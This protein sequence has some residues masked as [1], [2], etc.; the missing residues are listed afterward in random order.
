VAAFLLNVVVGRLMATQRS[1]IATLKAFGYSRAAISWHFL[2]FTTVIVLIGTALGIAGGAW[3]GGGLSRMYMDVYRFPYLDYSIRGGV[4]LVSFA[5]SIAAAGAGTLFAV[6]KAAASHPRWLQPAILDATAGA[7]SRRRLSQPTRMIV[8]NI[9]R[10]PVKSLLSIGGVAM[11]TA[12]LIL[13]VSRRCR[14]TWSSRSCAEL[15]STTS[16]LLFRACS[17]RGRCWLLSL[18]GV[19]Y[20][21]P[22]RSVAARFRFNSGPT[23]QHCKEWSRRGDCGG[24]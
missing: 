15:N 12:I 18:P 22:T 7:F 4:L 17:R 8:R 20:A 16:P 2:K 1:Q 5:V 3:M 10:R 6:F 19:S 24:Y 9:E 21:E 13:E 14:T 11:S 23:G